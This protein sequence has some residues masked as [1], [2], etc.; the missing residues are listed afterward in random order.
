MANNPTGKSAPKSVVRGS[1]VTFEEV[2]FET[3]GTPIPMADASAY[4][5]VSIVA[6]D[7]TIISTGVATVVQ[8]GH[9]RFPWIC[10]PLHW[11]GAR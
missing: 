6:P 4:P 8:P 2:F 3:D 7:Q 9:Y 11:W 1:S 5:A 10:K